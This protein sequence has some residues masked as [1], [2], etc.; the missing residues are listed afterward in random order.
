MKIKTKSVGE[1]T[2]AVT[3]TFK[4]NEP[5]VMEQNFKVTQELNVEQ[6]VSMRSGTSKPTGV[7]I[8]N[9]IQDLYIGQEYVLIA[10]VIPEYYMWDNLVKF[11]S[12][13]PDVCS[14]AW[15]Y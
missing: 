10:Y 6:P 3:G 9:P 5:V 12:D 14:V 4:N 2:I 1:A 7:V 11:T 13:N 8:V 15:G